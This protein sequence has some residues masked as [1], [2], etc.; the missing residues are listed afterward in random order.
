M[1]RIRNLSALAQGAGLAIF[2]LAIV[3]GSLVVWNMW[4]HHFW[5]AQKG[6]TKIT[7]AELAQLEGPEALPYNW[8]RLEFGKSYA[9][10]QKVEE[11]KGGTRVIVQKYLLVPAGD[12]WLIALVPGAFGGNSIAGQIQQIPANSEAFAALEKECQERH[13]G[14]LLPFEFHAMP[15]YGTNWTYFAV[16]VAMFGVAGGVFL[17]WGS[18]GIY[19]GLWGPAPVSEAEIRERTTAVVDDAIARIMQSARAERKG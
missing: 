10:S 9:T 14:R 15:D 17:L 2:G 16:V 1:S 12:R 4:Q 6:P 18:G 19:K 3:G 8:I 11:F 5:A 13:Q 7:P